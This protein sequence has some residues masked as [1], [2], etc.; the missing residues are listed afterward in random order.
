MINQKIQKAKELKS[1][2]FSFRQIAEMLESKPSTVWDWVMDRKRCDGYKPTS[3]T[4]EKI[5]IKN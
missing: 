2:G 4:K 1:N 5:D 3:F